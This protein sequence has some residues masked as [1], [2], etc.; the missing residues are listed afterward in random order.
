MRKKKPLCLA[1]TRR[2]TQCKCRPVRED[3]TG[4]CR[5]HGGLSTGPRTAEGK[6]KAAQNLLKAREA[7]NLPENAALRRERSLKAAATVRARRA[8][9]RTQAYTPAQKPIPH[10]RAPMRNVHKNPVTEIN[11]ILKA[12][13]WGQ[14]R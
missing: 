4:R 7:M 5:Y 2:G 10:A 6:A 3:G 8:R 1:I 13:A 9:Q 11:R 14:S 12:F